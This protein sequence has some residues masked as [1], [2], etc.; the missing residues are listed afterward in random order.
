LPLPLAVLKQTAMDRNSK[1]MQRFLASSNAVL[2]PHGKTTMCPQLFYRQLA[3]GAWGITLGNI[4]QVQ[5]A[6]RFGIPRIILANQL[7]GKSAIKY[8]LNEMRNDPDFDFYC[9]VD[10]VESVSILAEAAERSSPGRPLQILVEGGVAGR[11]AGART[12][13]D[14]LCVARAVK[15]AAP[16]LALRGGEGFEGVIL[17][18]TPEETAVK[19]TDFLNFLS[20]VAVACQNEGLF[21]DGAIILTAGGTAFYD[22]VTQAFSAVDL[23]RETLQVIMQILAIGVRRPNQ[24]LKFGRMFNPDPNQPA[25]YLV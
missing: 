1:W 13:E 12:L 4:A 21:A 10:S 7:V 25:L 6:R 2:A 24:R 8:V 5:V 3:D 16:H 20:D 17:E 22:L 9:L 11:R 14:A 15:E 18:S 19:V 23:G